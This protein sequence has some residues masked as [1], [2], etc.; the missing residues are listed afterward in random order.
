MTL[1]LTP[2]Q[3]HEATMFE[4]LMKQGTVKRPRGRPRLRP[5]RVVGDKG[6]TGHKIRTYIRRHGMRLTIPHQ[7]SE[8]RRG[9]FARETYRLRNIVERTINRLKQFRRL[10]T[11]YEKRAENYRAMCIIA[12]TILWLDFANTP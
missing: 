3:Q 12:A 10:A 1:A 9:P 4:L 2:G 8:R 7:K 6:Y 11:R 5:Q